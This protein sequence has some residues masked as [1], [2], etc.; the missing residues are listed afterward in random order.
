M[1]SHFRRILALLMT[2]VMILGL[3]PTF[4][5]AGPA[6]GAAEKTNETRQTEAEPIPMGSSDEVWE[7]IAALEEEKIVRV[8]GRAASADAYAAL[9]D[10]IIALVEASDSF[11]EGSIERHGDFFYWVTTDGQVNGYSP[12][13]RAQ[14]HESGDPDADPEAYAGVETVSFAD[15]G[16]GP[17]SKNVAV[18][19]PYYGIDSSF[20]TQYKEE[21]TSIAQATGGTSTAYLTT[22]ATVDNVASAIQSC[23]VVIFDSHG[24]TDYY[25]SGSEDYVTKANT[26]YLCLQSGTGLTTADQAAVTGDYGTYYHAYYAGA[27]G[28]MKVYCVDGTAITNHM[29]G[30]ACNNLVWMAIC[31]GM[32]TT[33][34]HVPLRNKGVEVVFG[35]SQ[36]TTFTG[37]YQYEED[38]WGKMK[39]GETVATAFAYMTRTQK[40]DPAYYSQY[41][42]LAKARYNY[43]AFPNIVSSEDAYQGHRTKNPSSSNDSSANSN[44]DPNYGACNC[45]TVNSTWTL[46]GETYTVTATSNNTSWGTVSVEG[47]MITASPKAGYYAAGCTVTS[48]SASVTQN[49]NVF[50]VNPSSDC[51]VQINF[52]AKTPATVSF[53]A[54]G[55][56]EG[57]RSAY[58]GDEITLPTSISN[59]VEGWTFSGWM[60]QQIGE[61]TDKPAFFAPGASYT[62]PAASVTL[63]A[64]YTRVED[65]GAGGLCYKLLNQ[66]PSD[67]SGNYVITYG[68]DSNLYAMTGV[69][70]SSSGTEIE[71][72][73]NATAFSA[74]GMTLED[75][76]LTN[77]ADA[78]L[79]TFAPSGSYYS[80]RSV[81]AGSYLGEMSNYYLGA[82]TSLNTTYCRWTPGYY[83]EN[84]SSLYNANA[85]S[86]YPLLSFNTN[87]GGMYFWSGTESNQGSVAENVRL[88]KETDAFTTY[89]WTDPEEIT[90]TDYTVTFTTPDG[91]TAPA[92]MVMNNVTGGTLPTADAPEGYTFLGWVTEDYDNVA[93]RPAQILTGT[94]KPKADITLKALYTYSIA[95]GTAP[96]LEQMTTSDTFAEGDKIVITASGTGYGLYQQTVNNSYVANFSFTDDAEAIASDNK[97]WLEVSAASNGWYLGD[98]ENGWLYTSGSNNLAINASSKTVWTLTTRNG[99]LALTGNSRYLSCRTDLTSG[100]ANLWR[101]GGTAGT[102]GTTTLVIYKLT[103]GE[104]STA[105]YTTILPAVHE[106]TPADPVSENEIPATCTAAGSYDSVVYCS[107]CGEELSRETVAVP[108]LGHDMVAGTVYP[109]TCTEEGYTEYHCS[110]CDYEDIDDITDALGHDFTVEPEE[111]DEDHFL[112]PTCSEIG[113]KYL[114]CSRCDAWSDEA[115][116]IP[117]LGHAW[118]AW[119][120]TTAPTCTEPGVETRTCS[121]C[122]AAENNEL[123]ALGHDYQAA[124]T[125]PTC[126]EQGYT[127]RTCSRCG[128]SYV[129]EYTDALG[130]DWGEWAETTAPTCTEPGVG[131]RTC[132]R[133]GAAETNEL[134]ALGHDWNGGEITLAP[135]VSAEGERTYTCLRCGETRTE[136]IPALSFRFDDVQDES[137]YYFEPVYWAYFHDPQ[138][139]T[140]TSATLFSPDK[141]CTRGQV[142]TFLWR[143]GGCPEPTTE[144][145]GFTDVK[146]DAYYYKAMLWAVE[147]GITTGTSATTFSPNKEA[148]RAQVV[149]FLWR[150]VGAPT[151]TQRTHGFTDVKEGAYYYE[152]MLWAV[153]NGIASGVTKTSFGPY[154]TATRGQIV[155]FLYRT[156]RGEE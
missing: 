91:I 64:L 79:F 113:L 142:V 70:G 43:C 104:A 28:S 66:A 2:L 156:F 47:Y 98:D 10:E 111:T 38:F 22:N 27:N 118:G 127:T 90:P 80:V 60:E 23:A 21:G 39:S 35:H 48:G 144:T 140:G 31:L 68:T 61:T 72:N 84:A 107:A 102:S 44:N 105:F 116:E 78:Y 117:A 150:A 88:W 26:S 136:P 101:M 76:T 20:T 109:A 4:A 100:N 3:T 34:M 15:K 86:S 134:A 33:G 153:E 123:A 145:H 128:D 132:S 143:A 119:T 65:D 99:Y 55:V 137:K 58:V 13:L 49:G 36:S 87:S 30:N 82:Y 121:R 18:F 25:V 77:V 135:T 52:A 12:R 89:Y 1:N 94:Y 46:F 24:D 96:V 74:S 138:I 110:R 124:V 97:N 130:H 69:A 131:T 92:P 19:Q 59:N 62:I 5:A 120:E 81:S 42:T 71:T 154:L 133:C 41:N 67:W 112:P 29:S 155:T 139:T 122:S 50:T 146:E 93:E 63:Y 126:T 45:Q 37:D 108:A 56:S 103:E 106:H 151:A 148:N 40:W 73:A 75:D 114:K 53:V 115:V 57:T 8:R 83:T 7:A 54:S 129:G 152:A 17:A 85:S 16:G 141:A 51:T 149:T 32:A 6:S 11:R 14:M 9:V 147:N 95:G 125:A